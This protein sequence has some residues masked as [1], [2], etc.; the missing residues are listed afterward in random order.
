MK[1][2][3][4]TGYAPVHFVCFRPVY[5]RLRRVPG[6]QVFVSGGRD[7]DGDGQNRCSH[8]RCGTPFRV[9]RMPP[10]ISSSLSSSVAAGAAGVTTAIA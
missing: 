5:E 9:V 3:L 4:F 10:E 8:F 7:P 2:I 1:R 6:V